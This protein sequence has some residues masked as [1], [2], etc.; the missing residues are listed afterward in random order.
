MTLKEKKQLFSEVKPYW[1]E[2]VDEAE[3]MVDFSN[4][5]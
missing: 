2:A 3:T 5:L 1:K 4:C